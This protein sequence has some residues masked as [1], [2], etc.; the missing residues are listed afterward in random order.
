MTGTQ[1]CFT[2]LTNQMAV[3]DHN[4]TAFLPL[5]VL[6]EHSPRIVC[7]IKVRHEAVR[8][9]GAEYEFFQLADNL[10][11]GQDF[12]DRFGIG[13]CSNDQNIFSLGNVRNRLEQDF[14][15]SGSGKTILS[16]DTQ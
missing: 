13:F 3:M 2:G 1:I 16:S 9:A 8:I 10:I 4:D 11:Y 12:V 14:P 5:G 6:D 7:D 15:V